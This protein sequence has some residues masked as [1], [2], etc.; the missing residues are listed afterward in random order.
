MQILFSTGTSEPYFTA[1]LFLNREIA[2][3]APLS[4]NLFFIRVNGFY[5]QL[6]RSLFFIRALRFLFDL[7]FTRGGNLIRDFSAT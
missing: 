1:R 7:K 4:G 5:F 3:S 2:V 6:P